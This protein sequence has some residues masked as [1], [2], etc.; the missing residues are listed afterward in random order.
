MRPPPPFF[1]IQ[2]N[3]TLLWLGQR[4]FIKY[5]FT[6][7]CS[8]LVQKGIRNRNRLVSDSLPSTQNWFIH[9]VLYYIVLYLKVNIHMINDYWIRVKFTT[10]YYSVDVYLSLPSPRCR[11]SS[12][13]WSGPTSHPP[14]RMIQDEIFL[15]NRA[16]AYL[17]T[18]PETFGLKLK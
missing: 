4:L 7:R 9:Y 6:L 2:E 18:S 3:F 17:E 14:D 8:T 13:G 15:Q 1:Q 11:S 5:I 10:T 12:T 16:G